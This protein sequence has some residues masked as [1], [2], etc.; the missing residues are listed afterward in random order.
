MLVKGNTNFNCTYENFIR[1]LREVFIKKSYRIIKMT[2]RE[3]LPL[4]LTQPLGREV[5][6]EE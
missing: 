6:S 2:S 1:F 3:Y 5:T 4:F